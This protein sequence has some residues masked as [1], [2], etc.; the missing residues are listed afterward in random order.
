M[1]STDKKYSTTARYEGNFNTPR[2]EQTKKIQENNKT[3]Q[4]KD[5]EQLEREQNNFKKEVFDKLKQQKGDVAKAIKKI[6]NFSS[7]KEEQ[8]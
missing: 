4:L 8:K 7:N 5:R 1:D 6:D 2:G 3:M